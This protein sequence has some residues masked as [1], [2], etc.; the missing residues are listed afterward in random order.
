M[1]GGSEG[2]DLTSMPVP[3]VQ[4]KRARGHWAEAQLGLEELANLV[5][6]VPCPPSRWTRLLCLY[7]PIPHCTGGLS[8]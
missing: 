2:D 8:G 6:D 4:R 5:T 7:L 1:E 3:E